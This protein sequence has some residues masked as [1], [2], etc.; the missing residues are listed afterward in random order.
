MTYIF[1]AGQYTNAALQIRQPQAPEH[2]DD[3]IDLVPILRLFFSAFFLGCVS[4]LGDLVAGGKAL[5]ILS[6]KLMDAHSGCIY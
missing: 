2:S 4:F 6:S 1:C 5:S 3:F